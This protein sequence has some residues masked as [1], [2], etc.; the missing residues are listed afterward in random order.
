MDDV[1]DRPPYRAMTL[2]DLVVHLRAAD[3]STR[4]RLV[5]EFGKEFH[6]EPPAERVALLLDEP[7]PIGDDRWDSLLAALA[8]HLAA[9]DGQSAPDW[10]EGRVL[11][12]FWFPYNTA[13][14]RVDAIVHAPSAFRRRGIFVAAR[15][16]E[17]A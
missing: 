16:F 11:A 9:G 1:S 15:E 6:H 3:E 14:A 8:E 12:S 2:C 7:A 4:W 5:A 17:V 10:S 13:A